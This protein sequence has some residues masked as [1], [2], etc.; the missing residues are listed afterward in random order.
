MK[1]DRPRVYVGLA[2]I[3]IVSAL[4]MKFARYIPTSQL[5][6]THTDAILDQAFQQSGWNHTPLK[7]QDNNSAAFKIRHYAHPNCATTLK[8]AIINPSAGIESLVRIEF[9]NDVA[10]VQ[11]GQPVARLSMTR[12]QFYKT[13]RAVKTFLG[14]DTRPSLPTFA[15]SPH[16]GNLMPNCPGP[17][18]MDQQMGRMARSH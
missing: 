4:G 16:P 12:H 8:A 5:T 9:G 1:I 11:N 17:K 10:F 3:V 18:F 14:I 15:V 7:R 6:T 13:Q 2:A